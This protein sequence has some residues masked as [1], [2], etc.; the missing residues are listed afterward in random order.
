MFLITKKLFIFE[1]MGG[2][3]QQR[4]LRRMYEKTPI[5]SYNTQRLA[6]TRFD[7]LP[8]CDRD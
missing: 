1:S 8:L 5:I 3:L 6:F 2:S 7:S 4:F